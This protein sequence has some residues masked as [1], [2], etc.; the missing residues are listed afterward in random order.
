MITANTNFVLYEG[1]KQLYSALTVVV[2]Y[3]YNSVF[4]T[5]S[6][7]IYPAAITATTVTHGSHSLN[8]SKAAVDAKT[9]TG[10]NPSD[11]LL[12]QVEQ[13]V[14]DYLDGLSDNSSVTFTVI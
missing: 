7:T 4:Q 14:A 12:N 5:F 10:T 3:Y 11:K 6:C 1:S 8:I 2:D 9:G 13:V